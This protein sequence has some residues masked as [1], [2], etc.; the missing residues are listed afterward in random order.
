MNLTFERIHDRFPS[1]L[2]APILPPPNLPPTQPHLQDHSHK[3]RHTNPSTI[4]DRDRAQRKL[5]LLLPH[6]I[7]NLRKGIDIDRPTQQSLPKDNREN[8]P[9]TWYE[10]EQSLQDQDGEIDALE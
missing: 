7:T 8:D 4:T 6:L 2:I 5:P 3:P 9:H 10:I 1:D